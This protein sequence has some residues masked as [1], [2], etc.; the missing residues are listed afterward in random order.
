MLYELINPS[1]PYTFEAKDRE[2]ATLAVFLLSTSYEARCLTEEGEENDV[3][4]F[5]FGGSMI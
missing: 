4:I 2:T 1:D 5:I 3:P